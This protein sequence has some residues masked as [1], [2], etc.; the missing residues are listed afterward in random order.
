MLLS[1][2]NIR[3]RFSH[4]LNKRIDEDMVKELHS[5]VTNSVRQ[6]IPEVWAEISGDGKVI[7]FKDAHPRDQYLALVSCLWVI[8]CSAIR[9][10][11]EELNA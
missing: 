4:N 1:L 5:K 2:G 10:T 8:L 6:N 9:Q 7:L 3:N 11:K